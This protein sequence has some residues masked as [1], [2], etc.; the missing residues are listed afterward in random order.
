MVGADVTMMTSALLRHGP[1]H[2]RT[3]EAEILAW[4]EQREYESVAQL[5]GSANQATVDDPSAYERANYMDTLHS[6]TASGDLATPAR[7]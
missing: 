5:R 7:S 2:I 1:G 3:V 4:M 6:W